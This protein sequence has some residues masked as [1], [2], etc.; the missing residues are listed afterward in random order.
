M[1]SLTTALCAIAAIGAV[2]G[3]AFAQS[4]ARQDGQIELAGDVKVERTQTVD[5][6]ERT[7]LQEPTEVVPGDRLV[8]TTSYRNNTGETVE[9]FVISNPLPAA[10]RLAQAGN[11]DV[12]VDGGRTFGDL[13]SLQVR[14][15]DGATRTAQ[16]A[17]VTN[18]RWVIPQLAANASGTV[19]YRGIVR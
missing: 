14:D 19:E 18:L 13:A 5:G 7:V 17:D 15:A 4:D 6:T 3:A 11:F 9:N 8:F 10:V 2:S 16:L 1:N 12:S